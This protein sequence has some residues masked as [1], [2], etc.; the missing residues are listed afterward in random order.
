M[1]IHEIINSSSSEN[2]AILYNGQ[3]FTYGELNER[4][5]AYKAYLGE[6]GVKAG[7]FV[8]LYCK[9]CPEFIFTYFAVIQ[10]GA[11]IVPFN[12]MLT[13]S[14]VEYIAN[15]ADMKHIV[16][17]QRLDIDPRYEQ[18]VLPEVEIKPVD[19][20]VATGEPLVRTPDDV[21]TVIYTSGTTG[22]PKGAMLTHNNLISNAQSVVDHLVM[23]S[24][25]RSL[26]VLPMFH[27]FAWTVC[28]L[29]PL[30]VGSTVV[31]VENFM[32]KDVIRTIKE[33]EVSLV[34]GVPTMY[35]YYLAL[36]TSE[37][38]SSVRLFISGGAS[39]PVEVLSSFSKKIG[40]TITEGYGLSEASPVVSINPLD[41][42][43]AGSIGKPLPGV[44]VRVRLD[45]GKD[46][47]SMAR[48]ELLVKGP[49]VMKGYKNLPEVTDKTIVDGWLHTGDVAYIDEDGYIFIVDR[50]KDI[51]IV[52]GLNVYPREIEELLYQ[53]EG[54]S[55]ASVIGV[56]DEKRGE[57][58]V[59][60]VVAKEGADFDMKG[61][62]GYLKEA[63]ASF[64]IPKKII[65]VDELPKNATGKIMK[66]TLRAQ[67]CG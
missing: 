62:K 30:L 45:D 2:T 61:L 33:H 65:L 48:G 67:Y 22:Q 51:V 18:I 40:T 42:I 57:V 47:D 46:A 15:D 54:V 66:K 64:K 37:D 5:H 27:S 6:I 17:M 23:N 59:A 1:L 49:N 14:E 52:N 8:G 28:V 13:G 39:L 58:T 3:T 43:K 24:E 35:T 25:D 60:Y 53:Y 9:N 20:A 16:T 4:I 38:F 12:R 44:E 36:G 63:L 56:P 10:M 50:M 55:E 26:C 31:I 19:C 29:A 21:T 32:P 11:V 7:D 41:R 34:S